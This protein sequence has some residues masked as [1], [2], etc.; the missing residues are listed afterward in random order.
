MGGRAAS[1]LAADGHACDGLLLLAYPL[2]P[3]GK[4]DQLRDAHLARITVPM[5]CINGTRDALCQRAL[6]DRVVGG[7]STNFTMHWVDGAD[8]SFHVLKASGR[9]DAA[10][11]DEIGDATSRWIGSLE[12]PPAADHRSFH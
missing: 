11:L 1:M 10:V 6:M 4:P 8:H 7:L 12:C 5:L 3:A 2:H 9:D